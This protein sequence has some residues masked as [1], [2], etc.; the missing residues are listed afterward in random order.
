MGDPGIAFIEISYNKYG[1][2]HETG[3]KFNG[4]RLVLN[5]RYHT[6]MLPDTDRHGS[7]LT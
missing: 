4:S 2:N 1:K 7:I 3:I 6:V 5:K